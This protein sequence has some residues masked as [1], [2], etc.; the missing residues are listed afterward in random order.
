[1]T[2]TPGLASGTILAHQRGRPRA[3]LRPHDSSHVLYR[4]PSH[5]QLL[6]N[7]HLF[8]GCFWG[9]LLKLLYFDWQKSFNAQFRDLGS[10]SKLP[11]RRSVA[12]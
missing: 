12:E 10:L 1:M 7:Q 3:V 9:F 5:L 4:Q 8:L 11:G 2:G 6:V